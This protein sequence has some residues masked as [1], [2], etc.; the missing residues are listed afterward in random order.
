MTTFILTNMPIYCWLNYQNNNSIF[1]TTNTLLLL[2][3]FASFVIESFKIY[4]KTEKIPKNLKYLVNNTL[5]NKK[6]KTLKNLAV[7]S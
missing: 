1:D 5:C 7:K 3:E 4:K 6:F 2:S